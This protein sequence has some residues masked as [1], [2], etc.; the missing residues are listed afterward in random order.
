VGLLCLPHPML[1]VELEDEFVEGLRSPVIVDR[2]EMLPFCWL[3]GWALDVSSP[4]L[5]R[6]SLR[7]RTDGSYNVSP[8][9]QH[10]PSS[11]FCKRS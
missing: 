6:H 9:N 7:L 11:L 4:L 8:C 2:W 3:V 10:I 1:V 5:V